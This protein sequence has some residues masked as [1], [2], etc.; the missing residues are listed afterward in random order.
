[1]LATVVTWPIVFHAGLPA[2]FHDWT[3]PL[4]SDR[5]LSTWQSQVSAWTDA[6]LGRPNS[7]PSTNPLSWLKV[8]LGVFPADEAAKIYLWTSV[9]G[10]CAGAY[11]LA[12]R[13]L[14][15]S[16]PWSAFSA[17]S[18]AVGP[19]LFAKIASG[20]SSEWAAIGAFVW[21]LSIM[22]DAYAARSVGRAACAALL[23]A[24]S[25]NQLQYAVFAELAAIVGLC[26]F[27][28]ARPAKIWLIVAVGSCVFALP[29]L[30]FL[31]ARGPLAGAEVSPPYGSWEF[32]QSSSVGDSFALLGYA[33]GYPETFLRMLGPFAVPAVKWGMWGLGFVALAGVVAARSRAVFVLAGLGVIGFLIISGVRGPAQAIWHWLFAHVGA[34]AFMREFFHSATLLALAYAACAAVALEALSRRSRIASA[35][36]AVAVL[37]TS[38]IATWFGGL[39]KVLPFVQAP[40]YAADLEHFAPLAGPILFLPPERPLFVDGDKIGGNDAFDWIGHDQTSLFD[41]YPPGP[42]AYA[43][44]ALNA[45]HDVHGMLNRLACDLVVWRPD[46]RSPLWKADPT[47]LRGVLGDGRSFHGAYAYLIAIDGP[48]YVSGADKA[49][50]L[51][52]SLRQMSDDAGIVYLD[53]PGIDSASA[54]DAGIWS[55]DPASGW[56]GYR[57]LYARFERGLATPTLGVATTKRGATIDLPAGGGDILLWAP[58]GALVDGKRVVAPDYVRVPRARGSMTVSAIGP[59]AIGELG[60]TPVDEPVSNS[61]VVATRDEPW[62][63]SG[64]ADLRGRGVVVL[65]QSYDPGWILR[66]DGATVVRHVRSDGFGNAWIVDGEGTHPMTIEYEPQ[67]TTFI[68]LSISL[69]A[70]LALATIAFAYRRPQ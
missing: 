40:A 24:L 1:M 68:L 11:R 39:A 64:T 46:V 69:A 43:V 19:W 48:S 53:M 33:A 28:D 17:T 27:R 45:G 15:L 10:A 36:V 63:Y 56:V 31:A 6:G 51:P 18:F 29:A 3:W 12:R 47:V 35:A 52:P 16:A 62:R 65:R 59:T 55:P 38:G 42:L 23:F 60:E 44:A 37:A 2:F 22:C 20:Q 4:F 67:Q 66:V 5:L 14:G 54:L 50:P 26:A 32:S 41:Y 58:S 21:G 70:A 13:T 49:A 34:A 30:W 9:F 7:V 8:G 57:D 61:L 25:T